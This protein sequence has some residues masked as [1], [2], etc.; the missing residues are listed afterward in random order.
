[1]R[2]A[3]AKAESL[4]GNKGGDQSVF[5]ACRKR[6]IAFHSHPITAHTGVPVAVLSPRGKAHLPRV[7]RFYG[8]VILGLTRNGSADADVRDKLSYGY[9]LKHVGNANGFAI[10]IQLVR[11]HRGGLTV[12]G[13]VDMIHGLAV[14]V[15]H[16]P[17]F[18]ALHR[19][20]DLNGIGIVTDKISVLASLSEAIVEVIGLV[21][22]IPMQADNLII[23]RSVASHAAMAEINRCARLG[24]LQRQCNRF[25][26]IGRIQCE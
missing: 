5:L 24:C 22:L 4:V 12:N 25:D 20:L 8:D 26:V 14:Y 1:M 15:F 23:H 17:R 16:I 21:A 3:C 9:V 13:S 2:A 6:V 10:G 19:E 7:V 18:I 11:A